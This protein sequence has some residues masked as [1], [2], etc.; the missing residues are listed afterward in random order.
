VGRGE[1]GKGYQPAGKG[2]R[3]A[4]ASKVAKPFR[5][6]VLGNFRWLSGFFT[7]FLDDGM[8]SG[9]IYGKIAAC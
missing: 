2:K 9:R 1:R 8:D 3:R 5:I 6:P 4:A 7:P